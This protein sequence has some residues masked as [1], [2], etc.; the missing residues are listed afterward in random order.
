MNLKIE[1][2]I[3]LG[4]FIYIA[5]IS[6]CNTKPEPIVKTVE[7]I[8]TDSI[9]VY[10]TIKTVLKVPYEIVPLK[11][12]KPFKGIDLSDTS[13]FT[14]NVYTY[15]KK[16]SLIDYEIEVES[17]CEPYFV[18]MKYD[19]TQ[20]TILD[21]VFIRDSV[22]TKEIIKKSFMSFGGQVIGNKNYFGFAPQLYYHHKSGSNFG[23]G[24]D[25]INDNIHLTYT[26]KIKLR[27]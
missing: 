25:L 2:L 5:F 12:V 14:A 21:S 4:L 11:E 18:R 6:T 16:D 10:D 3:I 15:A 27:R 26:K 13:V 1:Y 8:R 23:L 9:R 19:L 22:H 24:Y 20:V 7:T 17:E